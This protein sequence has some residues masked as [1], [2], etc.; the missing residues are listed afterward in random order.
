MLAGKMFNLLSNQHLMHHVAND[1]EIS[2]KPSSNRTFIR[3]LAASVMG[4]C[5]KNLCQNGGLAVLDLVCCYAVEVDC[6]LRF[7]DLSVMLVP[8]QSGESMCSSSVL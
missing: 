4:V 8:R 1:S 3:S 6:P 5:G 2:V 7:A